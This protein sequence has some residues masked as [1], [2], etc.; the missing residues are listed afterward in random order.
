MKIL[1]NLE[2]VLHRLHP[3]KTYECHDIHASTNK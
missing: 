2:K 1:A 3:I